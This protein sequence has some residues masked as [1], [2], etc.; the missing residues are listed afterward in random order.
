MNR[1]GSCLCGAV[2][3]EIENAPT[4]VGACHCGMCR[5]WSGGIY[6]AV[7]LT[8]DQ[9]RFQGEEHIECYKSSDWAERGFCRKCGSSLFYRVTAPGPNEGDLHLGFGTLDDQSG[10]TLTEEIFIDRKPDAYSFAQDTAKMTEA[11]MLEL[12]ADAGAPP[13]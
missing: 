4:T 11:Q 10:F 2:T 6:L 9:V 3:Y 13:A 1:T 8:K 7:H 5:K 12:F